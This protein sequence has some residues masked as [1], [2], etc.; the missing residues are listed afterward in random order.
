MD[1]GK[2]K[3]DHNAESDDDSS[4]KRGGKGGK[5][6]KT[7]FGSATGEGEHE[8]SGDQAAKPERT[9]RS[10]D[11]RRQATTHKGKYVEVKKHSSMGCAVITFQSESVR[12][13]ILSMG[14]ETSISGIKV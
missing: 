4:G 10:D 6:G 1:K 12:Q 2:G 8:D 5:K 7:G 3:L 13:A 14:L 11:V 9:N